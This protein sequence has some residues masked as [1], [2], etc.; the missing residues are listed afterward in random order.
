MH[1]LKKESAFF[2]KTQSIEKYA[3]IAI[4]YID[5]FY[6]QLNYPN[7]IFFPALQTDTS[8]EG[9]SETGVGD[10][11]GMDTFAIWGT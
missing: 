9:P 10:I 1:I 4:C 2:N 8:I 6:N 5:R 7:E 11:A 3:S